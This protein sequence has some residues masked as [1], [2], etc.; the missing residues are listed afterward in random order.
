MAAWKRILFPTDFSE[1]ADHALH[2]AVSI[3]RKFGARI[4]VVHILAM[5]EAD[6]KV[7]KAELEQAVSGEYAELVDSCE[8]VRAVSPEVGIL[9][10]AE[11]RGADL[12]VLGTHGRTGLRHVFLGSIAERVVQHAPVACLTVR[13]PGHSF[14]AL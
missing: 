5:H 11:A 7:G 6:P 8:T 2:Y 13:R 10:T 14:Q 1:S 12:I 4:D 3:A 9:E